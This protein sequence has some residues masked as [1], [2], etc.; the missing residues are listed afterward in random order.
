MFIILKTNLFSSTLIF[1]TE[2]CQPE[3]QKD[4]VI[5]IISV[6]L[7]GYIFHYV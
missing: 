1:L 7:C 3:F 6:T 5:Y 2:K 4:I